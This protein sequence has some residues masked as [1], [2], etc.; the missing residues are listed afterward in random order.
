MTHFRKTIIAVAT[1]SIVAIGASAYASR[2]DGDRSQKM[3][4]RISSKLEL[5]DTQSAALQIFADELTETRELMQ[6]DGSSLRSQMSDLI[7][8]DTFDQGQALTMINDRAAAIQANAPELVAAAAG[9][10]DGL[11]AE[12]KEQIQKMAEKRGHRG[13]KEK[14]E[15]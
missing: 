8:A 15:N 7:T 11:S 9:F 5:N 3:V 13:R 10:F 1:L 4:E 2:G 14:D 6:G 12:Q